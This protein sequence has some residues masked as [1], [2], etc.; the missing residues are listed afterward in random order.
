MWELLFPGTTVYLTPHGPEGKLPRRTT[1]TVVAVD[2]GGAPVFLHTHA[3]NSVARHLIEGGHVPTLERAEVVRA[4]VPVGRSRFD[5]LLRDSE[6]DIYLEVK[7]CTLFGNGVAMFP[8]AITARG[9][10]HLLE[11]AEMADA[12]IRTAVLFLVHSPRVRHFMPDYHTD[13]AFSRTL[14]DVRDRVRILPLS[15]SWTPRLNL[16][17]NVRILDVPWDYIDREAID[18]GAYLLLLRVDEGR[19]F[20]AGALGTVEVRPGWYVYVG[21]ATVN[22]GARVER[23]LRLRKRFHWH[24]DYLR[25]HAAEVVAV[26]IRSTRR[27]ECDLAD[28]LSGMLEQGAARFGASD[29]RCPTHLFFSAEHPLRR[30]DFH[31]V[32]QHFRMRSPTP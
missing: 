32:L 22:L 3:N 2:A 14:L 7:S 29:C 20:E 19:I 5:F 21:S 9:R 25:A 26:P 1:H 13:L 28:A 16:G 6:G 27:D 10:R 15:V 31:K 17:R 4:E 8:D 12:G 18:G 24:I 23:H 30:P 11:L